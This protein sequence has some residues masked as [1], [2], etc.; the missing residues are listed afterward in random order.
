MDSPRRSTWPQVLFRRR[1]PAL[2]NSLGALPDIE[3]SAGEFDMEPGQTIGRFKLLAKIGEGGFGVVHMAD[4]VEPIQRRVALKSIKPGMGGL[5]HRSNRHW[6]RTNSVCEH[7]SI[8]HE[9]L[10]EAPS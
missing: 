8:R 4:Q 9:S 6:S 2:Q 1:L 10:T 3:E 5:A 7:R